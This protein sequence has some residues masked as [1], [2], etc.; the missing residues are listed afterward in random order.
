MKTFILASKNKNKAKEIKEILGDGFEIITQDETKAAS[1]DVIEGGNTFS[2]NAIKKA[3]T[4]MEI[5]GLPT[6]ADDS[7]LCVDALSG[8]PGIY[9]ARYAGEGATDDQKIQK[10]FGELKDVPFEERSA[11]FV[12]VIA[13]AI[14]EKET[15]T[16]PG[17]VQ[18]II[19]NEKRGFNGFGY[20]PVFYVPEYKLTMAELDAKVKNKISHRFHASKKLAEYVRKECL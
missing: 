16:F 10:L 11:K 9:S 5:T 20:D 17:E 18:G 6:I 8:A 7:G 1:V 4:I 15:V 14:P 13:L 19:T 3:E 2:E 12:C